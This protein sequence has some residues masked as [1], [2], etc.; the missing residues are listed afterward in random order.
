M[1]DRSMEKR[2]EMFYLTKQSTHLFMGIWCG[3]MVKDHS[4]RKETCC[5][6]FIGYSF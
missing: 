1:T 2:M 6:H 4:V 3:N 5:S